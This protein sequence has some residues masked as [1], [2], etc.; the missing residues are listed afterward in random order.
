MILPPNRR[1]LIGRYPGLLRKK[2]VDVI[3]AE[4]G[5]GMIPSLSSPRACRHGEKI[6]LL[7]LRR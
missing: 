4:T 3:S 2:H 6:R 7:T 1:F 5:A